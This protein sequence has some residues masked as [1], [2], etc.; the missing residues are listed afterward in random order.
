MGAHQPAE[1]AAERQPGDAG[2]GDHPAGRRHA[3]RLRR[4]IEVR[5]GARRPARGPCAAPRSTRTPRIADRSQTIAAVADGAARDVV[6]AAAHRERQ[7]VLAR[8]ADHGRHVGAAR[9]RAIS[10]GRRSIIPFQT[11]RAPS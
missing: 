3:D 4:A 11:R 7:L 2:G 8:E 9:G 10:S 1:A 5:P 6:A